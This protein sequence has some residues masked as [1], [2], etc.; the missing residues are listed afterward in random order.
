MGGARHVFAQCF[1]EQTPVGT[2]FITSAAAHYPPWT[3]APPGHHASTGID[4]V[5]RT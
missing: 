3:N 5:R 1:G 2:A 4:R